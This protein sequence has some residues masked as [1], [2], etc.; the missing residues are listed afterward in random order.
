[1]VEFVGIVIG[2]GFVLAIGY[3]GYLGGRDAA[4]RKASETIATLRR[5]VIGLRQERDTL[6]ERNTQLAAAL[7]LRRNIE[8]EAPS[9]M[10]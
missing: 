7:Y 4:E 5:T 6:R 9:W 10:E 1:M 2:V 3:A 8:P